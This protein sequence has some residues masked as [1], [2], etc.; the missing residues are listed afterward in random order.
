MLFRSADIELRSFLP[1]VFVDNAILLIRIP[2][3]SAEQIEAYLSRAMEDALSV[4]LTSVHD[5]FVPVE[6]LEV[7]KKYAL[8]AESCL[9]ARANMTRIQNGG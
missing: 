4:G 7:F 8:F 5:A 9:L 6:H 3:L 2:P 1:G